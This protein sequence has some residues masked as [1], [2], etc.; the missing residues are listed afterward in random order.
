M[1]NDEAKAVQTALGKKLKKLVADLEKTKQ[2][3]AK[4]RDILRDQVDEANAILEDMEMGDHE[5]T[6]AI[7]TIDRVADDLS[8]YL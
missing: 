2:R 3:I 6:E 4:D 1:A 5:L 7:R 8:K